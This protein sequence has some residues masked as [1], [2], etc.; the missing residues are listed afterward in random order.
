[1]KKL[2]LVLLVVTLAS[3]LF[4]GCLP[5]G[6]TPAEG[7]GEGEGEVEVT[8]D[9][10][11]YYLDPLTGKTFV[12]GLDDCLQDVIVTIPGGVDAIETYEDS[13]VYVAVKWYNETTG[14][15]VY[16]NLME[17]TSTDGI[18][19]TAE[20]YDFCGIFEM[21]GE[22]LIGDCE[23]ICLVALVKHPCCP[24]DEIALK[25]VTVD[26]ADPKADLFVTVED[27]ADECVPDPCATDG[28]Y[29]TWTSL[30]AATDC[31][32][33]VDCCED[34]CSGL[35][36]WTIE[37]EP[38]ACAGPCDLVT[39]SCPVVGTL[40]CG[41][42]PYADSGD[43]TI[44]YA[45]KYTLLDNVG[46]EFTDDWTLTIG[47]DSGDTIKLVGADAS[48][49]DKDPVTIGTAFQVYDGACE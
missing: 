26:G 29:L 42:L 12:N 2:L 30:T 35:A 8:L 46:N 49:A 21:D 6:T 10:E 33:A 38:D 5:G 17:A 22:T 24:G 34:D 3:F 11:N 19:W 1:M 47:E 45:V 48:F 28:V 7:E 32:P 37:V 20:D 14:K 27:C 18:V 13:V 43:G 23:S 41:C 39:G 36:S 25:V 16:V 44:T 15:D 31:D 4:V 9:V 40:D